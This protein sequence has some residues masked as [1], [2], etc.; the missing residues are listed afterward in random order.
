M[1][2]VRILEH[3]LVIGLWT[4]FIFYIVSL[5]FSDHYRSVTIFALLVL[6][7]IHWVLGERL[8]G[9]G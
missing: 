9:M 5:V 4:I 2:L 3:V 8:F 1:R 6:L 7:V